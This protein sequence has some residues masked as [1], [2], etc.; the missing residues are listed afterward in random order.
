MPSYDGLIENLPLALDIA[1]GRDAAPDIEKSLGGVLDNHP[2]TAYVAAVGNKLAVLSKTPSLP[3]QF[4]IINSNDL[5]AF[6]LPGGRVYITM[7]LLKSMSNEAQLAAVLGHEIGHAADRHGMKQLGASMGTSV[8]LDSVF[9]STGANTKLAVETTKK[10]F[11]AGYS[12]EHESTA[13]ALGVASMGK[14]GYATQ[15]A[16]ELMQVLAGKSK[17]NKNLVDGLLRSHP[18]TSDRIIALK[19]RAN[20]DGEFGEDR[21][22]LMVFG[23]K[24]S[25]FSTLSKGLLRPPV[26]IGIGAAVIGVIW[27]AK[28]KR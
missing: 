4:R 17:E 5:N 26:L 23:K 11:G 19:K 24:P 13:D 10:L 28:S 21:Y 16:V 7:G 12:R 22:Q 14:S 15:G 18:Y 2:L 3:Y 8:L 27:L 6:A 9:R 1:I 20:A 25:V